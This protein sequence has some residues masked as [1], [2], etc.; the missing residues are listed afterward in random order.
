MTED[1]LVALLAIQ[2]IAVDVCWDGHT[3]LWSGIMVF[4]DNTFLTESSDNR[5]RLLHEI[6]G[7]TLGEAY[8]GKGIISADH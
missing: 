7:R 1:E 8:D 3:R 4:K 2:G 5:N 6:A